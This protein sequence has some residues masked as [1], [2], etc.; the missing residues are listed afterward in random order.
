MPDTCES[1]LGSFIIHLATP[2]AFKAFIDDDWILRRPR[3]DDVFLG[4]LPLR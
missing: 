4:A 1:V 3:A 2:M